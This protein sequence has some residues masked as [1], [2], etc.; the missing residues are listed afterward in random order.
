MASDVQCPDGIEPLEGERWRRCTRHPAYLVSSH[1]RV[2][3]LF[4]APR[5]LKAWIPTPGYPCVNAGKTATV[6]VLVLEAFRGSRPPG[7]EA[8][9]LDGDRANPHLGNLMWGTSTENSDDQRRH[10][11]LQLGEAHHQCKLRESQ[12]RA[13]LASDEAHCFLARRY[14]VSERTIR[15]IRLGSTWSH[16]GVNAAPHEKAVVKGE[17]SPNAKLTEAKVRDILRDDESADTLA[18]R[19]GVDRSLIYL[20]RKRKIWRHVE[21]DNG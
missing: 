14:G 4:A 21:V 6:H 9:H 18:A 5:L 17:A 20:V 16:L 10:E 13:I 8:R 12:V 15:E 2:V 1:G 3:S 19:F 11:T 7:C